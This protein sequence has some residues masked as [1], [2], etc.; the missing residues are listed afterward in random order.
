MLGVQA[1][2]MFYQARYREQEAGRIRGE[3]ETIIS[4][5]EHTDTTVAPKADFEEQLLK[6]FIP[7]MLYS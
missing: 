6:Q 5:I 4:Q 3:I 1:L 7:N 2:P